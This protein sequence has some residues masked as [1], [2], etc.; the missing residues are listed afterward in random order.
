MSFHFLRCVAL[1]QASGKLR[2]AVSG[3]CKAPEYVKPK[4]S[5]PRRMGEKE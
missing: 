3:A 1:R 4:E 5:Q 2:Q